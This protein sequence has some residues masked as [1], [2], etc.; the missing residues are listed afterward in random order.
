MAASKASSREGMTA[1][2]GINPVLASG[3]FSP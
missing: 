1:G 3:S 2:L